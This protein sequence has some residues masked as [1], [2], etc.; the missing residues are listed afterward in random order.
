MSSV[1]QG[2]LSHCKDISLPFLSFGDN[3]D[4]FLE[5]LL[6]L[7]E[8]GKS[9]RAEERM[10]E[11]SISLSCR[12]DDALLLVLALN[13]KELFLLYHIFPGLF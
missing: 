5:F 3:S 12:R 10:N 11:G 4:C 6:A 8:R 13:N 9:L 2:D 7:L 1:Q